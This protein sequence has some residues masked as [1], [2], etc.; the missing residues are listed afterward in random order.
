MGSRSSKNMQ[1]AT[2][3]E[4]SW[5][6]VK[7]AQ[8][9]KLMTLAPPWLIW[10]LIAGIGAAFHHLWGHTQPGNAQVVAW[11]AMGLTLGTG[12]LTGV[13]WLVSHQRG[14]LG[15]GSATITAFGVCMWITVASVAG[16]GQPVVLW[17]LIVGGMVTAAGWNIRTVIREKHGM[18]GVGDPLAFLFDAG[19]EKAGLDGARMATI[20]AGE[21]KIEAAMALPAGQ[22]VVSDV[23][24]RT[25]HIEGSM[26]LPP[27]TMTVAPDLDRADRAKVTFSDPRIMRAPIPWPGPSHPGG[28]IADPVRPGVWQDGDDV[29]HALPDHHFQVMGK[30]GAG[31]SVGAAWN[32]L[33]E[34]ITRR[35]AVVLAADLTKG[36]QTLGPLRPALHR[37]ETTKQGVRSLITDVHAQLKPRTDW[38]SRHGYV[39]W[40]PGCGL[41]YQVLWL[42]EF[43][44]IGDA[45]GDAGMETFLKLLKAVRSAGGTVVMSL[46]RSDW[47]QMPTIARAQLAHLCFGVANSHDATFGLSEAQQDAGAR[48]ELWGSGQ[49]GMAYLDAPGI[50]PA[51]IAMPLRTFGWLDATGEPDPAALAAHAAQWPAAAKTIDQF[52]AAIT[53]PATRGTAPTVADAGPDQDEPDDAGE[54]DDL[55]GWNPQDDIATDDPDPALTADLDD[56]IEDDPGGQDWT[57]TRPGPATTGAVMTAEQARQAL[58]DRITAWQAEGREDFTTADLAD[59]WAGAGLTR[60]WAQNQIRKLRADGVLGYDDETQRHTLTGQPAA[61]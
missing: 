58:R 1:V 23:Q 21:R 2:I 40:V 5:E 4:S 43:P 26:G 18:T 51:R 25:E 50:D 60:Q 33:A 42:E 36:D 53:R 32:Y 13:T 8:A 34:I 11:S 6:R 16:V 7:A 56:P 12:V 29:A 59:L 55:E 15:R 20:N 45:L 57:F 19:K 38:L 39:N 24:K 52:T 3:E 47:T 17:L 30:S 46:Q 9:S 54:H 37:F 31:K 44:D 27:G 48:P 41:S 28:S 22:K 61:A 35:D 14:I 49:P 10:P